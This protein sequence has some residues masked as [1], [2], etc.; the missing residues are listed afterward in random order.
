MSD[1][2]REREYD[3]T[4]QYGIKG[5]NYVSLYFKDYDKA[6]AYYTEVFGPPVYSEDD[7]LCGWRLGSTWLTLFQSKDG[8]NPGGNPCNAEFA[9]QVE[10]PE[11]V[12]ILHKAF[13]DAGAT[14]RW[15]PEDT[16]MYEPMRFSA[17]DDPFGV[18]IDVYYPMNKR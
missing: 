8:T 18:R 2:Q 1:S 6:V 14:D 5:L 9:I 7:P 12:D 15:T 16:V 4:N 3:A 10:S 11:R 17:V 13:L